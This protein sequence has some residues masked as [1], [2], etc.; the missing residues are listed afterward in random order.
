PAR[1]PKPRPRR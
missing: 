1:P